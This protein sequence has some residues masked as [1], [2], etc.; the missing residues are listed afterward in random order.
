MSTRRPATRPRAAPAQP[1]KAV[2][3]ATGTPI[4][5]AMSEIWVMTKFLRPDLLTDAGLGRI[6]NWAGT[7]ARPVTNPE[8]NIT[9]TKLTMVTRM[10]SYANVPQLVAMIDQYRDVVTAD[11][12][13]V[14]LPVMTG[15]VP[16][17]VEFDLGQHTVD[18]VAD[19]D[20]RLA[21]LSGDTLDQD[22]TLKIATDGRNATMYPPLANLPTPAPENSR[23]EVAADL[24]WACHVDHA[25]IVIPADKH[26]PD[27]T[28]AFQL[29]FCDRGTPK[30]TDTPH[31]RN[32]Y[33]E[34]RAA[35]ARRGMPDRA[36]GVHARPRH[37]EAEDRPRA[38][39]PRRP[40]PG[41]RSPPP[42]RAAPGSTCNA[43]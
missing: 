31:S 36:G 20:E 7:F 18:F 11:Q 5:N 37:P 40:Y 16:R 6:D 2:S 17:N 1:A 23:V 39:L 38:S 35:L 33:T 42:R 27:M 32:V 34:L 21:T 28:G 41:T 4:S 26:G 8:M 9:A 12:I 29:V 22:N 10:S 24:I 25:D 19:L 15:G 3:F 13:P 14:R 43:R 30:P